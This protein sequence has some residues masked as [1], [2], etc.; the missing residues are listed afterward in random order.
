MATI[1]NFTGGD[2]D[3]AG[4]TPFTMTGTGL[5]KTVQVYFVDAA[6]KKIHAASFTVVSDTKVTGIFPPFSSSGKASVTLSVGEHATP[7]AS[8][9]SG[10]LDNSYEYANE[11]FVFGLPSERP[12]Q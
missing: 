4:G 3:R 10:I 8:T 2:V 7:T 6:G 11:F 5:A 9:S 12:K 1:T